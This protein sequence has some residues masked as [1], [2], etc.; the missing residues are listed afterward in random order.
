MMV[1]VVLLWAETLVP[2]DIV[3]VF[4]FEIFLL[5]VPSGEAPRITLGLL[6][7]VY[8]QIRAG[9]WLR[10]TCFLKI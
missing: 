7:G 10:K 4:T 1:L 8:R 2:D 6:R 9:K 5:N 3:P